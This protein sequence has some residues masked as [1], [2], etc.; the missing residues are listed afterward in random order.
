MDEEVLMETRG[1][2]PSLVDEN[3]EGEGDGAVGFCVQLGREVKRIEQRRDFSFSIKGKGGK[4]RHF[5]RVE[6]GVT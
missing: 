1:L 5:F 3:P 2:G 6:P 4:G